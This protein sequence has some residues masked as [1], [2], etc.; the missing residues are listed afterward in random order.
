MR[1]LRVCGCVAHARRPHLY[2]N[3]TGEI[4]ENFSAKFAFCTE[5]E[6]FPLYSILSMVDGCIYMYMNIITHTLMNQV[7]MGNHVI[8]TYDLIPSYNYW[9]RW[10]IWFGV[11]SYL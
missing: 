6:S 2:N 9:G 7:A 5:R 11:S 1:T 10:V 3:W 4:H 8:D